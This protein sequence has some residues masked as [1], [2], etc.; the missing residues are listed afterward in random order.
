MLNEIMHH[1]Y[2]IAPSG[3]PL[4]FRAV[5]KDPRSASLFWAP[6]QLDLQNGILRHY[7]IIIKSVS[8][9]ETR[10]ITAPANSSTLTGLQPHT[11]Y[12]FSIT[13]VTIAASPSSPIVS[14]KT[15]EGGKCV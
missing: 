8:G 4:T 12:E 14:V 13:A 2:S 7:V 6:P 9:R 5:S 10:T 15:S 11:L 3:P 1:Y